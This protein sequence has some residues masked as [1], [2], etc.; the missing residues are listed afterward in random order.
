M[1]K[2]VSWLILSGLLSGLF[3]LALSG[4]GSRH[5]RPM[6][7]LDSTPPPEGMVLIPA[8]EFQM[9]GNYPFYNS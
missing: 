6:A 3:A 7:A 8:G 9:G 1:M 2:E 4:C 5:H